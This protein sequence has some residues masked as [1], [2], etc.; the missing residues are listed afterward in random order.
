[1]NIHVY[2][3]VEIEFDDIE[4]HRNENYGGATLATIDFLN[5]GTITEEESTDVKVK[6][7]FNSK[8]LKTYGS[9]GVLLIAPSEN[10]YYS[11]IHKC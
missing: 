11:I 10:T 7:I 6:H 9:N 2:S 8:G 3:G 5:N 1:M 4:I